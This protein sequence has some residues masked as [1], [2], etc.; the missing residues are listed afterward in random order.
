MFIKI[1]EEITKLI[2]KT[3]YIQERFRIPPLSKRGC[4]RTV[5]RHCRQ[6]TAFIMNEN[7]L[8]QLAV[9]YRSQAGQFSATL[10]E[11]SITAASVTLTVHC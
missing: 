8:T 3:I 11:S 7:Q 2:L 1:H 9:L 10:S 5:Q 4:D 6:A